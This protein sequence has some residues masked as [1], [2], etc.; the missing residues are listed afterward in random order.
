VGDVVAANVSA[1]TK[2]EN[3]ILNIAT[4]RPT[5]VNQLYEKMATFAKAAAAPSYAPARAG[6]L[7]R[8][9]LS[10]ERA[11]KILN[12]KPSVTIDKGLE[13]TYQYFQKQKQA[14]TSKR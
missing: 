8:S 10:P 4:G 2:G 14:T 13:E 5:S 11:T 7:G 1:L 3:A 6:E 9:V 12:W